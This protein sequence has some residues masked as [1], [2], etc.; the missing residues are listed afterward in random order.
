M[1]KLLALLLSLAMVFSLVACG[2]N[3]D[4]SSGDSGD[5]GSGDAGTE[6]KVKVA[7]ICNSSIADGGWNQE[8]Y[9]T[10]NALATKYNFELSTKEKVTDADVADVYRN[11]CNE[12]YSIIVDQ[13]QYHCEAMAEIAP[14]YP[15]VTF[16]CVNGY[17]TADNMISISSSIWEYIYL[18]GVAAG[19]VTKSNKIGLITFSLT[20]DSARD[21]NASFLAGAKSVNDKVELVHVATG[22]FSDLQKGNEMAQSLIDQGCDVLMSNSGDCNTTV[23]K[24]C[25]EKGIYTISAIVNR[26]HMDDTYIIGS[27]LSQSSVM[28]TRVM[29]AIFSGNADQYM[30]KIYVGGIYDGIDAFVVNEAVRDKLPASVFENIESARLAMVDQKIEKPI[31]DKVVG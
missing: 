7:W 9:D 14:E 8:G 21:M 1:K 10:M 12:G 25:V 2:G 28:I 11:Y 5:A 4:S 17:V 29:D 16:V 30:G 27:G 13:E 20:S 26:N 15:E 22:S 19:S 24:L 23:T 18:C 31:A 3:D 6:E